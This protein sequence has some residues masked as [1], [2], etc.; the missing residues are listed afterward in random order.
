MLTASCALILLANSV[1]GEDV[2]RP[3][4]YVHMPGLSAL[5]VYCG[6]QLG[7]EYS[8]MQGDRVHRSFFDLAVSFTNLLSCIVC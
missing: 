2:H 4:S 7:V 6:L 5:Q 8:R 1:R 3:A